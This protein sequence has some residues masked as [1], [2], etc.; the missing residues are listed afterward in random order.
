VRI[1]GILLVSLAIAFLSTACGG[2]G[3]VDRTPPEVMS[4]TW[5]EAGG[6]LRI[7]RDGQLI[8]VYRR[9]TQAGIRSIANA[10]TELY[11]AGR[12]GENL[13]SD[14]SPLVPPQILVGVRDNYIG[15]ACS[16]NPG[17]QSCDY[18]THHEPAVEIL[19][20]SGTEVRFRVRAAASQH[21]DEGTAIGY[22]TD[23]TVT[24]PYHPELTVVEYEVRTTLS[25]SVNV[26]HALR[27][28]P[29]YELVNYAY[30]S[31]SYLQ[32]GCRDLATVP[33]PTGEPEFQTFLQQSPVC[34]D[35]PWAV[36]H[37]NDSGNLGMILQSHAWTSGAPE[38]LS[39]TETAE[40]PGRPNL[41]YRS[42][43]HSRVYE[44]GSWQGHIVFLAY[45]DAGGYG[46]VLQFREQL[47]K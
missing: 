9:D 26:R 37:H 36:L 29:F 40:H 32:A 7:Y 25:Q 1:L 6:T 14:A 45:A 20:D 5:N 12:P 43:D 15:E 3:P 18:F 8:V 31:V 47:G 41:Y 19:R 46:P 35:R 10:V 13:L 44:S 11:A 27:P 4:S 24:V 38:L 21:Y 28:L 23:M 22:T 33:I 30:D 16:N 17:D 42:A 2:H 34:G 39:Y